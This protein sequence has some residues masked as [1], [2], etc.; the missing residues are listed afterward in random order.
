MAKPLDIFSIK[1]FDDENIYHQ[2]KEFWAKTIK[3]IGIEGDS[4][5]HNYYANG[6]EIRDGNPIFSCLLKNNKGI[7]I[8]QLEPDLDEPIFAAWKDKIQIN[9]QD[10]EELVVSLQLS[11][12]TLKEARYLIVLF[13]TNSLSSSL[14]KGSN[15]RFET[16]WNLIKLDRVFHKADYHTTLQ[17]LKSLDE[18]SIVKNRFYQVAKTFY[19]QRQDLKSIVIFINGD[20]PIHNSYSKFIKNI[21]QINKLVT[22]KDR[23]NWNEEF[24]AA[25]FLLLIDVE[26]INPHHTINKIHRYAEEAEKEFEFI[27][28]NLENLYGKNNDVMLP[29]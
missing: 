8:I 11:I 13:N 18:N 26:W 1:S 12:D 6:K 15:E 5:V 25:Q 21:D 20:S 17:T 14:L 29:L 24:T 4:Y 16:N 3:E 27:K 10:I 22:F 23:V 2:L 9:G 19:L 7:R 28:D